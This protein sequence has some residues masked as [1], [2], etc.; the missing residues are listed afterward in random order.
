MRKNTEDKAGV[1]VPKEVIVAWDKAW[2]DMAMLY[3]DTD[4]NQVEASPNLEPLSDAAEEM[5]EESLALAQSLNYDFE[6]DSVLLEALQGRVKGNT[7]SIEKWKGMLVE[8]DSPNK[9]GLALQD[10][11]FFPY[12][13]R[14]EKTMGAMEDFELFANSVG[15]TK[16]ISCEPVVLPYDNEFAGKVVGLQFNAE[17][18]NPQD[19]EKFRMV[20]LHLKYPDDLSDEDNYDIKAPTKEEILMAMGPEYIKAEAELRE[21]KNDALER[22]AAKAAIDRSKADHEALVARNK[23]IAER[24]QV[25]P[26]EVVYDKNK[27]AGDVAAAVS[28]TRLQITKAKIEKNMSAAGMNAGNAQRWDFANQKYENMWNSPE[29]KARM[30]QHKMEQHK[31]NEPG[32]PLVDPSVVAMHQASSS[33]CR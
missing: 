11:Y 12:D 23:K 17:F 33:N 21:A 5:A 24:D 29:Y 25:E 26:E 10:Y 6:K 30:E 1:N 32:Q 13:D 18:E 4:T 9:V 15:R 3:E 31:K 16:K 27:E 19:A 2:M 28:A 14:I 22:L 7:G 8:T 20:A